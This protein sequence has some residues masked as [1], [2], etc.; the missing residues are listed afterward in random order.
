MNKHELDNAAYA[1]HITPG[2]TPFDTAKK[3]REA[4]EDFVSQESTAALTY[5]KGKNSR[6]KGVKELAQAFAEQIL[7]H[8][9]DRK[10]RLGYT[11]ASLP[12]SP[13]ASGSS[14]VSAAYWRYLQEINQL[15][16]NFA[17]YVFDH[18][19]YDECHD[20]HFFRRS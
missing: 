11:L 13:Y 19:H 1:L 5:L 4:M 10:S 9:H 2:D 17:S 6:A 20:G 15:G 18:T 3:I 8:Q 7:N 16:F 14:K 12:M